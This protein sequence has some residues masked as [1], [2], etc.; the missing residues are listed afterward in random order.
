MS[1]ESI[2]GGR[3]TVATDFLPPLRDN[4]LDSF[5]RVMALEG[6]Q[7]RRDFPGRRTVRLELKLAGGA[8]QAIY[9]KRYLPDYLSLGRRLLRVV[10]WPGAEDE[11]LREWKMIH[12]V[13]AIGIQTATPV[14]VGQGRAD[15]IVTTSFLMTAEI[16]DGI[17]GDRYLK[18]LA[19]SPRRDLL[20]R[21][22]ELARRFHDAG[23][24]HKDLY[25]CHV[26]VSSGGAE[27]ELFLIDLQRVVKPCCFRQRWLVK[28][29]A[30]LA[31]SALK[32][33]A[34]Q[35]DLL[36]AYRVYRGRRK[37]APED[38]PLAREILRRVVWLR[39]RTPKHDVGFE[40]LA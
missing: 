31:Y 1:C 22:A 29:L 26:L 28:D 12:A 8:K 4:G 15:G 18:T 5:E 16:H 6:G 32:S 10:H 20:R 11:A 14:A 27:P 3:M 33:G 2:D 30:A 37:L 39:T 36:A 9:L 34:S 38:R 13:R 23:F 24:V 35:A 19:A 17:E 21:I 7:V 40:Q 25:L